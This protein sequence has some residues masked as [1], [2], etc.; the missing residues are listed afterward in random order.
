MEE[1]YLP[2]T[3][4]PASGMLMLSTTRQMMALSASINGLLQQKCTAFPV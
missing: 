4:L 3:I 1:W 2:T